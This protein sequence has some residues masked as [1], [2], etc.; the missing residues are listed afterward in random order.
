MA[1][2]TSCENGLFVLRYTR[3]VFTKTYNH[4]CLNFIT[5]ISSVQEED[6]HGSRRRLSAEMIFIELVSQRIQKVFVL[7]Y[8]FNG[9]F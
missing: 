7:T 5:C 8:I 1:T 9:K 6:D 2:V 3:F 4:Y